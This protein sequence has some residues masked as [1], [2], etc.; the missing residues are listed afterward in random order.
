[1]SEHGPP[2][3]LHDWCAARHR[4]FETHW[5]WR[6]RCVMHAQRSPLTHVRCVMHAQRSP[7]THV[8]IRSDS[9]A[10]AGSILRHRP[11]TYGI[12]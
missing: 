5:P 11:L 4:K 8:L 2:A 12:V 7:L 3:R 6:F 10:E 9:C 1:M